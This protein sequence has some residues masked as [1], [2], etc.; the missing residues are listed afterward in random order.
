MVKNRKTFFIKLN[1]EKKLLESNLE[2]CVEVSA[3]GLIL[4]RIKNNEL[5]LLLAYN[6]EKNEDLGG[7]AEDKDI[8]I[9]HTIAREANEES[10]RLINEKSVLERIKNAEYIISKTSKYMLFI[11]PANEDEAKLK[12]K[13]FGDK[14]IHDDF[15]RTISWV[16]VSEFLNSETIKNKLNFRLKNKKIFDYLKKLDPNTGKTTDKPTDKPTY[17]F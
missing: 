15:S 12:S 5:Q 3:G 17:L 16:P 6:R 1:N 13:D 7:T 11:I 4:Y 10:N 14:E 8:D 9:Y 2:D